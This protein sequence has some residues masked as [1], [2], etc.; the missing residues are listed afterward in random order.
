M[1]C[2]Q[3][4]NIYNFNCL[5]PVPD[6]NAI[7]YFTYVV[8]R[9]CTRTFYQTSVTVITFMFPISDLTVSQRAISSKARH[10]FLIFPD[11]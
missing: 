6:S 10:Y 1:K 11:D 5:A 3:F 4:F 2:K 7:P 8:N 9:V